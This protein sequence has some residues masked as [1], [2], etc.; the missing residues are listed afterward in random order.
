MTM[1]HN[2]GHISRFL[3][4]SLFLLLICTQIACSPSP[5]KS[6]DAPQGGKIVY[7]VVKGADTQAAAMSNVLRSVHDSCG[8]RPQVGRVFRLRGTDSDAVFFTVVNHPG[9]NK[10]VAGLVLASQ[11]GPGRV[12]AAM[13]SDDASRF[14]S[15]VNPMLQQLFSVWHP[16]EASEAPAPAA[17]N[18]TS[19]LIPSM[20][21]VTLPDDT[22]SVSLPD[23]WS[24]DPASAG[25]GMFITGPRGERIVLNMWFLAQ[26]PNGP[27]ITA[28]GP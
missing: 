21:R 1:M 12:E 16:G 25:G 14:G 3:A 17:D 24:V 20:H 11:S 7:G 19:A 22:A 4:L 5:L 2:R 10:Y 15:T 6:I 13:V 27:A 28:D 8:E 23:G 26:D 18:K 9:G